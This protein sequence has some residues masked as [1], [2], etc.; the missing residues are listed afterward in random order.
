MTSNGAF[1]ESE[2]ALNSATG[3]DAQ[4]AKNNAAIPTQNH[5]IK[6]AR[7]DA[8]LFN[9]FDCEKPFRMVSNMPVE[10]VYVSSRLIGNGLGYVVLTIWDWL[11]NSPDSPIRSINDHSS[12]CVHVGNRGVHT[13]AENLIEI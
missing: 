9:T 7:E 4:A 6:R 5:A 2:V 8:L 3:G 11:T 1:P 10:T 13:N 12:I